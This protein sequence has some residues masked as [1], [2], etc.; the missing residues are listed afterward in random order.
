M[1]TR[2]KALGVL[3][4]VCVAVSGYVFSARSTSNLNEVRPALQAVASCSLQHSPVDFVVVDGGRTADEHKNNVAGGRSWI[5]RSKHQ[6]GLAIDI[7]AYVDGK[8]TYNP[9]PYYKIAEA[10]YY[11]SDA[12]DTPITWG[13]EWRVQDLMHYELKEN[14]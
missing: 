8:I 1:S 2:T 3:C 9:A 6:D 5:K 11:C 12:L 10:F 7:A 14:Q 13:G 4:G